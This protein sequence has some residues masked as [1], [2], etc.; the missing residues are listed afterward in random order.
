[1]RVAVVGARTVRQ[2]VGAHLARHAADAGA[3][4]VAVLGTTDASAAEAADALARHM[5]RPAALGDV[6]AL[7]RIDA[8]LLIIASPPPTHATFLRGALQHGL[9]VLCEKPVAWAS[10]HGQEG[11]TLHD[12]FRQA[13]L[14]LR[15]HA[16]WPYTLPTYAALHP[17]VDL[18]RATT[19]EM[20][21]SPSRPGSTEVVHALPHALSLLQAACPDPSADVH[22]VQVERLAT[23]HTDVRFAYVT[24]ARSLAVHLTLRAVADPPRPASYAFDGAW[25]HREISGPAYAMHLRAA[26]GRR[27]PLPDPSRLLVGSVLERIASG[28]PDAADPALVP[29]MRH[30][31]TLARAVQSLDA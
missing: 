15:V 2:G 30:V 20:R 1:M 3:T 19:F 29:G 25:G 22:D 21:L 13:G 10:G 14:H 24:A 11:A 9:H 7:W 23:D 17:H 18:A 26:D 8:Q 4:V 27:I 12:A 6:D 28:P 5:P 16:Q 31:D